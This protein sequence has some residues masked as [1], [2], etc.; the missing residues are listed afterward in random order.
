MACL[1]GNCIHITF[2]FINNRTNTMYDQAIVYMFYL[3]G[4]LFLLY[5]WTTIYYCQNKNPCYNLKLSQTSL[6]LMH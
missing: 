2:L 5:L 1:V 6:F 4:V 3:S